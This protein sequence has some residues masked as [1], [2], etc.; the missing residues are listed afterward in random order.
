MK[1]AIDLQRKLREALKHQASLKISLNLP[2]TEEEFKQVAWVVVDYV[3]QNGDVTND[4]PLHNWV[5]EYLFFLSQD[6]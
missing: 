5:E 2:C 6:R 3:N 1:S 4:D